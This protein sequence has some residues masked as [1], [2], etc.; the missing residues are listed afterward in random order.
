MSIVVKISQNTY[1]KFIQYNGIYYI[2][3]VEVNN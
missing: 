2:K 3:K 1:N